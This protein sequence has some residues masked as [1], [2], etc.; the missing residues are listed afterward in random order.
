LTAPGSGVRQLLA[1]ASGQTEAPR[2]LAAN[3]PSR[4]NAPQRGGDLV[5][6]G[7]P[8]LLAVLAPWQRLRESQGYTVALVAIEDVQDEFAF[9]AHDPFAIRSFLARAL[10]VWERRP[11][12]VLLVG[13]ATLDPRDHM[14]KGDF[15]LVP[16][17][18]VDTN[19]IE[20][21][22]DDWFT[23]FD[24]DDIADV[25]V[26]RLPVRT[27]AELAI[28]TAKMMAAPVFSSLDAAAASGPLVFV[29]DLNDALYD[30]QATSAA[31]RAS[32]PPPFRFVGV[33]RA[34]P[35]PLGQLNQAMRQR[36]LLVSYVGHG[37]QNLW[38][39]NL[40]SASSAAQLEGEGPG[41][42]WSELTCLNGFFQD[43]FSPS[44]AE[45]VLLRPTGGAFGVWASSGL[46]EPA[47]QLPMGKAFLTNLMERGM[48]AGEAA[49]RAKALSPSPDVRRSWI[50]FGDP[51]W[52]LLRIP[53]AAVPPDA[54]APAPRPLPGPDAGVEPDGVAP[55]AAPALDGAGQPV[56]PAPGC[57]CTWGGARRGGG[58]P[59]LIAAGIVMA[60]RRARHSRRATSSTK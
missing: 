30:F 38:N 40:L 16:T 24:G 3:Q 36:P 42:F 55:D 17:K 59:F 58:L 11:R 8:A 46:T 19:P 13:D 21:A 47:D 18:L 51:T 7:P 26:G 22:S 34:D 10:A 54:G 37:S 6:I 49:R 25:P 2:F 12:A 48:T 31:V 4:W 56:A 43:I 45:A 27:T 14:G 29:V 53:A 33:D 39:G 23:D 44:L 41:A 5:V 50:L 35:D 60:G 15:D 20:T 32:V 1:R 9:G 57:S 28:L 52:Q